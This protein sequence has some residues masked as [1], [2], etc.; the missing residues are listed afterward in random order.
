MQLSKLP[1]ERIHGNCCLLCV[2][3]TNSNVFPQPARVHDWYQPGA[4]RCREHS[5]K[6]VE[7]FLR[8]GCFHLPRRATG[9][10]FEGAAARPMRCTNAA[11]AMCAR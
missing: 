4:F 3:V 11:V 5:F 6:F 7:K 10:F 2:E 9:V 1:S 8:K